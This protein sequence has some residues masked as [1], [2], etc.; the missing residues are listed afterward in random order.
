MSWFFTFSLIPSTET[1]IQRNSN[2]LSWGLIREWGLICQVRVQRWGFIREGGLFE[3]GDLIDH[4]RYSEKNSCGK[5]F[6]LMKK[7][8]PS[9]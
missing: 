8:T 5:K 3:S 2:N 7:L 9:S 1:E 4:L 6:P